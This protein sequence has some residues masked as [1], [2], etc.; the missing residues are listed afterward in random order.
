MIS[1]ALYLFS[2]YRKVGIN[3]NFK[4]VVT[5]IVTILC[6]LNVLAAEKITIYATNYPLQYFAMRIAGEHAIVELPVPPDVD[7]AFWSPK[8]E[9]VAL[10]Q[11]ADLILLNGA[12][13]EKWLQKVSLPLQKQVDTSAG[14]GQ[15]LIS[16][17]HDITHTHGL[18]GEHLHTGTAFTTWLDFSQAM[19]QAEAIFTNL[20]R[21]YPQ[22]QR[23]F[24]TNFKWLEIDLLELDKDL[25]N[26]SHKKADITL[27]ASHP[28]YQYMMRRYGL[29][30]KSVLW[31]P[32]EF[33][34]ENE[35]AALQMI[36]NEHP[37]AWMIWEKQPIVALV[38][39]L[40][41]LG[42]GSLVFDPCANVVNEGDF[43][44][45]MKKN[46]RNIKQAFE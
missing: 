28:V 9:T 18:E 38:E 3:I 40:E 5:F 23:D 36:I 19:Q 10:I 1:C 37:A 2:K 41:S 29:N 31:E 42:V 33:P 16:I 20:S 27:L 45:V 13:Y 7:P 32:D 34:S 35:W 17:N 44:A 14:F 26:I 4:T 22:H 30:I 46:V 12:N 43:L 21:R 39:K 6:S 11:T 15:D 24:E 8:A 25:T